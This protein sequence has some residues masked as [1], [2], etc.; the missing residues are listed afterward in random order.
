MMMIN[1]KPCASRIKNL[2][3]IPRF[4]PQNRYIRCVENAPRITLYPISYSSLMCNKILTS[5]QWI[6]PSPFRIRSLS[7]EVSW[8]QA[9]TLASFMY[10]IL[11]GAMIT[12]WLRTTRHLFSLWIRRLSPQRS[13]TSHSMLALIR[14]PLLWASPNSYI[15]QGTWK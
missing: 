2:K 6:H 7:M 4:S 13:Q 12:P 10:T 1:A 8:T 11:C 15:F 14:R 3:M 5:A 9:A